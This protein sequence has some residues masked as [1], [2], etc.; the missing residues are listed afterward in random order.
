MKNSHL[1]PS[2]S[3]AFRQPQ[4]KSLLREPSSKS[5]SDSASVPRDQ[6]IYIAGSGHSGSTLLD[7]ML[8][9]HSQIS[10][11]GE[12]HRLTMNACAKTDFELHRC[13]C[14]LT[15]E[16]CPFWQKVA[17]K[18]QELL[19]VDDPA[20]FK[21]HWITERRNLQLD[22]S[23][24]AWEPVST[25]RNLF[26]PRLLN[27]AA[28]LGNRSV[29]RLLANLN[30]EVREYRKIIHN[31]LDVYEAVRRAHKTPIVIDSTKNATRLQGFNMESAPN[32]R[33]LFLLRDGRAVC[34]SRMRR[35]SVSMEVAARVWKA[36]HMKQRLVH[37]NMDK[38]LFLRATY[39]DLCRAPEKELQRICS[40]LGVEFQPLMLDF[41]ADRHNLGGNPMRMRSQERAI[42][43]DE[44]WRRELTR[45]DLD[46]FDRLVGDLNRDLGYTAD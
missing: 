32:L 19:E 18:L 11:L 22:D 2:E 45:D 31:S 20:I 43:L 5:Q 41:R 36:E 30:R 27:V 4:E 29:W 17:V 33:V 9:G 3:L 39:E 8:G 37:R 6:L 25:G 35:Q 1:S 46:V 42:E 23:W 21:K 28:G 16:E 14:G 38:S 34:Y 24:D 7:M 40:W 44:K 12:V 13:T 10:S 26:H 15:I